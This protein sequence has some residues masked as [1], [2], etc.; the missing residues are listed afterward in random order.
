MNI[1]K[2]I[3]PMIKDSFDNSKIRK[4]IHLD[5]V[6]GIRRTIAIALE[7]VKSKSVDV[8]DECTAFTNGTDNIVDSFEMSFTIQDK[9]KTEKRFVH[10]TGMVSTPESLT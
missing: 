1:R 9:G 10:L 5:K 4:E 8:F 2:M 3:S 7:K 6:D